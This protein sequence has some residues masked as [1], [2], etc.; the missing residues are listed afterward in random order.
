MRQFSKPAL[1][2]VFLCAVAPLHGQ[3]SLTVERLF[4]KPALEGP[5][6][7]GITWSPDGVHIAYLKQEP[8]SSQKELWLFDLDDSRSTRLV[9]GADLIEG[10]EQLSPEEQALRERTRQTG[11]GITRCFWSP[12]GKAI[13]IPFS[14][15]VFRYDFASQRSTRITKTPESEFDP[16]ISPDGSTLSYVRG[17]EIV[18]LDLK[19]GKESRLTTGATDKIKN[20]ISEFVA[21][22]EMGRTTGYW[23]SPD[24]KRIAYLQIDNTPVKEF[25]IPKF[26]TNFT[27]IE[28]QEYPKAGESNTVVKVG[29][30]SASGGATTWLDLGVN[31]DVYIPRVD[32]LSDSKNIAVQVQSRNQDTVDLR[33]CDAATGTSTLLLRETN[34]HWVSLHNDLRFLPTRKQFTWMSERDG[35]RHLYV[36]GMD[37]KLVNQLTSGVWDVEKLAGVGEQQGIVYFT[38]SE[39]SPL[40][41]HLYSVKLDG[42]GMKRITSTEG[43]HEITLSPDMKQFV[44]KFSSATRPPLVSV[45]SVTKKTAAMVEGNNNPPVAEYDLPKPEFFTVVTERSDTLHAMMIRPSGFDSTR[46]YPVIMYVYGGPTSQVVANRW[47]AGGG[48]ARS[49]WH[50]MMAADGYLVFAVDGRGTPARGR[51]FQNHIHM[52]LGI[53]ELEDQLSGFGYLRT[54]PYVDTGRV[55][56]WGKSYG[57]FMTCLAMLH[58]ASPFKLGI[59]LAPV[60][61]WRNYDTHYTERYMEHPQDNLEG[62]RLSS[63]VHHAANLRGKL[64]LVHGIADDNVHFQDAVMLADALQRE[65]KQFDF[66]LYPRSTH[67]FAGDD[68]GTHLY[69]LLTRYI[70]ENL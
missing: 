32:W 17:G 12:D 9:R 43:W 25:A 63:P 60:T 40:E 6:I 19:S 58:T 1:L 37:G 62:Y 67:A 21:Q 55:M 5:D 31:S 57:G 36:F 53:P 65:N 38:A 46:R 28:R 16:K 8:T 14:G 13:F 51:V 66:M 49:L 20:G 64:L 48:T 26:L 27:D 35:F 54:L 4:Q 70:R 33:L 68:V 10:E 3:Q 42:T 23:W 61:D 56:I 18:V 22:E 44:D 69:N 47:G 34:S 29:V 52:R 24:S 45:M 30:V 50:R 15:D 2:L 11:S 59:A 41:R 7:S 39:K